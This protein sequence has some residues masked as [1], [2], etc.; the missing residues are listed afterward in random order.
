MGFSSPK[1]FLAIAS[2]NTTDP[3][4]F[5]AVSGSPFTQD[6]LY[7]VNTVEVH[8]PPLRERQEDVPLL[9]E[10]FLDQYAKKYQKPRI[11]IHPKTLDKLQAY[12][13]PGNIRELQ[14]AIERAVILNE[15]G[16]L[17]PSDF[18]LTPPESQAE[19]T[20]NF[21]DFNLDKVEKIVIRKAIEKH[22][23]NISQAAKELGLTRSALYRRLEKYGL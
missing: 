16:T 13:W 3:S 21:E 19:G 4:F 7:R 11:G 10:S 5:R 1:N 2:V 20:L 22:H 17:Q 14:H 18:L 15:S 12:T 8:L 23:G 9:V 6:L